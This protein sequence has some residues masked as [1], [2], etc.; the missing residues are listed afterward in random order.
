MI[1]L[2]LAVLVLGIVLLTL[3]SFLSRKPRLDKNYYQSHWQDI[4]PLLNGGPSDWYRAI[5]D[6]D[7]LLDHALKSSQYKGKTMGDR[8]KDAR[9]LKSINA[10]WGAHKLRNR[11]VHESGMRLKQHYAESALQSYQRILTELGA[12]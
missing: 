10:A 12:L 4:E 3:I 11:L 8:L 1:Q 7:K 5:I 2:G 9:D 6:A